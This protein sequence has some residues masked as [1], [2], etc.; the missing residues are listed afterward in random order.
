[1]NS[2][3]VVVKGSLAS[4]DSSSGEEVI[5]FEDLKG[6]VRSG[7]I[8]RRL[9]RYQ[10]VRLRTHDIDSLTRPLL[11]SLLIRAMS[12]GRCHIEDESP[13]WQSIGVRELLVLSFRF[14]RDALRRPA[15]LR[16]AER[17][18]GMVA[19]AGTQGLKRRQPYLDRTRKPL[20]LRAE[21]VDG[22]VAGGSVA[23]TAGVL[24]NL[25]E[26]FGVPVW[27]TTSRLP[28]VA[29]DIPA[30][31]VRPGG[32]FADF[33]E[34]PS[35][36]LNR[37]VIASALADWQDDAPAFIYQRY[38]L[39]SYSGPWLANHFGVPLVLEFNGSEVWIAKNWGPSLSYPRQAEMI[40]RT[41]IT[42][43]D[44]VVVVSEAIRAQ[45]IDE[46]IP[47]ERI[48]T[49]PNGVDVGVYCPCV[50]GSI[51]RAKYELSDKIVIGFIGTFGPWHGAEVLAKAFDRLIRERPDLRERVRLLMVGDG[52]GIAGVRRGLDEAGIG[53]LAVLTGRVP[54]GEGPQYLAACDVYASPHIPN[55]DGSRFFGSPTKLFEYMA[56]GRGIVASD[57]EQI[58]DVLEHNRTA[59]LVPPGDAAALAAGLARLIDD[60]ALRDRLGAAARQQAV[61]RHT[62]REHTRRIVERLEEL[63]A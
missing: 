63:C 44:L 35:L 48:L 6:W 14:V 43:A 46:S 53:D 39:H 31:I 36:A 20:Y 49:N 57:L 37:K 54:Q 12:R 13:G 61:E 51:V 17:D 27:I 9:L 42:S 52:P 1:M 62:W 32:D 45:L 30:I 34:L 26:V 5:R 29:A 58:G 21:F 33:R 3:L 16:R 19:A 7:E 50:D 56:M 25:R 18:A 23:H 47:A 4:P 41:A 8:L 59:Y 55:S 38:S 10:D 60:P 40:E 24:N 15:L 11:T 2:T 22:L 28:T